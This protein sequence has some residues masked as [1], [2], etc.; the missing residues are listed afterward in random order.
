ML[1]YQMW[2][3]GRYWTGE[4]G[5]AVENPD[6]FNFLYKYSPLHNVKKGTV[7][8]PIIV[9]TAETDDRVV[10]THSKKFVATLQAAA[11]EGGNPILIRVEKKAGHGAGKP[12]SKIIDEQ[13]DIYGFL[14]KVF[15]ME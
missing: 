4:Y 12:T 7:Y 1:R 14:F 3:V 9:T 13:S 6:H 2:T 15:G 8:P 10:P 5:N 11:D